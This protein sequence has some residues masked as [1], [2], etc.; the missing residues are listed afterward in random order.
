MKCSTKNSV[1]FFSVDRENTATA[2]TITAAIVT[3]RATRGKRCYQLVS[4]GCV[5][6]EQCSND[7][8]NHMI[9]KQKS[10]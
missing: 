2:T 8:Q 7:N 1:F 6:N 5:S 10:N 4:D 3:T 9:F